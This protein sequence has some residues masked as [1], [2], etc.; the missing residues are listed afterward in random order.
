MCR[1]LFVQTILFIPSYLLLLL[2]DGVT[3]SWKFLVLLILFAVLTNIAARNKR[4]R[5]VLTVISVDVS[6]Y[7][8]N[9]DEEEENVPE[10]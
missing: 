6:K 4:R 5:F 3:F 9:L 10:D 1:D 7:Q 8:E 2:I